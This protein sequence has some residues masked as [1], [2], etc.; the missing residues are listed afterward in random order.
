M[1]AL[2]ARNKADMLQLFL[3]FPEAVSMACKALPIVLPGQVNNGRA[4]SLLN[5]QEERGY[6]AW[7]WSS[8]EIDHLLYHIA[9]SH[10]HL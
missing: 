5:M 4:S 9:S 1:I 6:R 10:L 2:V 7:C 8:P 3:C